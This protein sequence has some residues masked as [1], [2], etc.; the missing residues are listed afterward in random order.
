M[1]TPINAKYYAQRASAGLII[2]EGTAVSLDAHG[3]PEVTPNGCNVR[4]GDKPAFSNPYAQADRRTLA[5]ISV[6]IRCR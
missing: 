4:I 1:P 3:Y 2:S 6:L 5:D